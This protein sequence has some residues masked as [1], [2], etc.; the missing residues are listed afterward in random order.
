MD[1]AHDLGGRT[2][3]GVVKTE[4]HEPPFHEPW[5]GTAWALNVLAFG[6]LRAYKADTY[7]HAVER[8]A[9]GTWPPA[10]ITSG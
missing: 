8:M 5:E 3:F 2:G 6:K 4:P 10:T 9:S 7:R 1:G